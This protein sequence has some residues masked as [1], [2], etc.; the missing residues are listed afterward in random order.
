MGIRT[1]SR[2]HL[3][4]GHCSGENEKKGNEKEH[5]ERTHCGE[6][7]DGGRLGRSALY[8]WQGQAENVVLYSPRPPPELRHVPD[9][10]RHSEYPIIDGCFEKPGDS[11]CGKSQ[12][13]K[14]EWCVHIRAHSAHSPE[15][16]SCQ[17]VETR[18]RDAR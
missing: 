8:V 1:F 12:P 6:R 11:N 2:Q 17:D 5:N 4:D 18:V 3:R 14:W 13:I 7:N 15:A 9:L 16:L 10:D